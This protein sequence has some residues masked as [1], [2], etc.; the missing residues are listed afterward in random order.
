VVAVAA[1][2]AV[3]LARP[4]PPAR[5]KEALEAPKAFSPTWRHGPWLSYPSSPSKPGR[6]T[7]RDWE[8]NSFHAPLPLA[9][10]CLCA[11]ARPACPSCP[12]SVR[13]ARSAPSARPRFCCFRHLPPRTGGEQHQIG[14]DDDSPWH[15]GQL[16]IPDSTWPIYRDR[17]RPIIGEG[18]LFKFWRGGVVM[19]ARL[20]PPSTVGVELDFVAR[21]IGAAAAT[22][23][24]EPSA[25]SRPSTCHSSS[26]RLHHSKRGKV[27]IGYASRP[28]LAPEH[29]SGG[30]ERRPAR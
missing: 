24:I 26:S 21:S 20:P 5:G 25:T 4:P 15:P 23:Q 11:A 17:D 19:H 8:N 22:L 3:E 2:V 14:D 30:R 9:G 18:G 28:F 27:A 10:R 1:L 7:A 16:S 6:R 29:G 12:P 13:S